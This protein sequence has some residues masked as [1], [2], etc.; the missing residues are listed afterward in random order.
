MLILDFFIKSY[1]V[2]PT[3]RK[4]GIFVLHYFGFLPRNVIL[5]YRPITVNKG[6][7]NT[8]PIKKNNVVQTLIQITLI[9]NFIY[10][11]EKQP[12]VICPVS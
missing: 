4:D 9:K 10:F 6:P 1:L 7:A 12:L 8:K 5:F 3:V 11:W 2:I